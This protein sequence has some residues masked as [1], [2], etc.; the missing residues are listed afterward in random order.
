MCRTCVN[1]EATM[2][3]DRSSGNSYEGMIRAA[4]T[5]RQSWEIASDRAGTQAEFLSLSR[6]TTAENEL[7]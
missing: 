2:Q 4:G 7:V 5:K 6:T 1:T 3:S